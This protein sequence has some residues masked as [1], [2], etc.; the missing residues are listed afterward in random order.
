MPEE[1]QKLTYSEIEALTIKTVCEQAVALGQDSVMWQHPINDEV[2][3]YCKSKKY[4][5]NPLY[6]I[7]PPSKYGEQYIIKF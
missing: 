3:K 7:N 4:T 2:K 1:F 5:I 6:S